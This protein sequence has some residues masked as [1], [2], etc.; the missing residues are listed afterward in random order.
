MSNDGKTYTEGIQLR[1]KFARW[2]DNYWYHYKWITIGVA[3]LVAVIIICTV[4]LSEKKKEDI[5]ILYAG[6]YQMVGREIE[7][8]RGVFNAVMPEDFDG[9]GEKYTSIVEYLIYSEDQIKELEAE[10]D[11]TGKHFDVNNQLITNNYKSYSEYILLGESAICFVDEHLYRE[12]VRYGRLLP[13][14]V[15]FGGEGDFE[16]NQYGVYLGKT[17]LYEEFSALRILPED[18]VICVLRQTV[19]GKLSKDNN[20]ENELA[21]FRA[22]ITYTKDSE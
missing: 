9:N 1:S 5:T 16:D 4:Q 8:I 20:Y 6:P 13:L 15:A 22:L 3:F 19:A 17:E 18:T 2:F 14:S 12:L 7:G 21:M 10:T 11:D